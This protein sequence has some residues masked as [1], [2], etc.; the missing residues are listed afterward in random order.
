MPTARGYSAKPICYVIAR[1][2]PR[3]P[4]TALRN[5]TYEKDMRCRFVWPASSLASVR[6]RGFSKSTRPSRYDAEKKYQK[7]Q[8]RRKPFFLKLTMENQVR[9]QQNGII[10]NVYKGYCRHPKRGYCMA[11]NAS[12]GFELTELARKSL[13]QHTLS[14]VLSSFLQPT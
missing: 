3:I 8:C 6:R 10:E 7:S 14:L 12:I 5:P 11:G 1:E 9:K 13:V 4:R 2:R